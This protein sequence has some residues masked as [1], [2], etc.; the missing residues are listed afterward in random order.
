MFCNHVIV[1]LFHY[2][3]NNLRCTILSLYGEIPL[4]QERLWAHSRLSINATETQLITGEEKKWD[5]KEQVDYWS[6]YIWDLTFNCIVY[7]VSK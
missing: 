1:Y 6:A 3:M 2:T 4:Q 7:L 5:L